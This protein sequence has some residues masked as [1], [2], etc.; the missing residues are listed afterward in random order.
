GWGPKPIPRLIVTSATY[1]QGTRTSEQGSR[2]DPDNRLLWRMAP[3]RLEAEVIRDAM[4]AAAGE[5]DRRM[6]GPGT[7]DPRMRRRSV[8][9]FVKRSARVPMMVLFDAP[10]AD[11]G[12]ERRV[13]T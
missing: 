11:Q 7:L 12:V 13:N 3:R 2:S 8:Y 10:D 1:R 4:L 9:F 5:L 6:F